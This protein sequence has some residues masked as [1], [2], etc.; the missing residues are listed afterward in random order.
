[1]EASD[2][3]DKL[4]WTVPQSRSYFRKMIVR[5]LSETKA[6]DPELIDGFLRYFQDQRMPNALR[7]TLSIHLHENSTGLTS[8]FEIWS[9]L[10]RL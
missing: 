3:I 4:L 9:K 8:A 1:M 2:G 6:D 10:R 5:Y 7:N